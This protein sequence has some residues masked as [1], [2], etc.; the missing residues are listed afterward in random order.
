MRAVLILVALTGCV[1]GGASFTCATDGD[2]VLGG[3]AGRCESVGFCSFPDGTCAD[4]SRFGGLSGPFANQCVGT[5]VVD[6][7]PDTT[8]IDATPVSPVF[9][10]ESHTSMDAAAALS[11]PLDVPAG[12]DRL[13][14]VSV[15]IAT[16]NCGTASPD[17]MLVS[18]N[19]AALTRVTAILGIPC[20]GNP[21]P[22][23]SEQWQLVAPEVG[24]HNVIVLLSG[25]GASVHSG[26]LLFTGVDQVAPVRASMSASGEGT[27]STVDVPSAIGD[28]VVNTVG[29]GGNISGPATGTQ[30]FLNDVD[31]SNTFNNSGASS[32]PGAA[33]TVTMAWLFA[34][35]DE[36]QT[37]SSS[38]RPP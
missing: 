5:A 8:T 37:I 26:A 28:L 17:V 15:Q 30:L 3:I 33:G 34:V 6:A 19:G 32:A 38:L 10:T 22:V 24:S 16:T 21:T 18:Y 2:C 31:G 27:S 11:Y 9:V 4:G 1:R 25:P 20:S 13:L 29:Q 7:G 23:K 14:L 12:S 35:N 36:W